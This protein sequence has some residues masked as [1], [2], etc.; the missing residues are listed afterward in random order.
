MLRLGFVIGVFAGGAAS[1]A[2]IQGCLRAFGSP[3]RPGISMFFYRILRRLLRLRVRVIG[4]PVTGQPVIFVANHMSW[5]DIAAIGSTVP[6][7]FVAKREVRAWPLIGLTAEL[8][9]TVFVDR[10]RR[11]Q[12]TAVNTEIAKRLA[13]GKSVVL[14]AEGTS[15]DGNRVLPFRSALIGAASELASSGAPHREVM[16]QPLSIS[17][18]HVNGLPMGRQHRPLVAWYGDTDLLPHL[19]GFARLGAIDAVIAF[20]EPV[21]VAGTDRKTAARS[22]ESSV[23]RLTSAALRGRS[24]PGSI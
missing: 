14:F 15:S 2:A 18:T 21:P 1:L 9:G 11:Q 22:I 5:V 19:R 24:A 7:H 6:V 23:R 17:Y 10:A 13:E 3:A 20:G 16:L 4:T 8:T 12:T